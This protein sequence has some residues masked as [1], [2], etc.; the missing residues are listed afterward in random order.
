M[1]DDT[2]LAYD[3]EQLCAA[4]PAVKLNEYDKLEW[5]DFYFQFKPE[6]AEEDFEDAW[7]RFQREKA[8]RRTQ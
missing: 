2:K 6:A 4:E 1:S 7:T 3:Y 5:R 8:Q